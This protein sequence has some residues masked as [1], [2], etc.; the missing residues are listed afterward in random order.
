MYTNEHN[1]SFKEKNFEYIDDIDNKGSKKILNKHTT[2]E[3]KT[4]KY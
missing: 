3:L 4:L 1:K 2:G